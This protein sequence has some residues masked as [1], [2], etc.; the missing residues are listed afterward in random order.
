MT[1]HYDPYEHADRLGLNVVTGRVRS[2]NGLWVPQERTIILRRGM[3]RLLERSV[4]AHEI[5]HA[6]LGHA[7]DRPRYEWQADVFAAR[8]L[9]HPERLAEVAR[10][11]PDQGQWCVELDVTPHLLTTY[12]K[13]VH[14]RQRA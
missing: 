2:A 11:T 14:G 10:I 1:T 4:L 5:G 12:F 6:V 13:S 3:R 9:I 7:D 8:R